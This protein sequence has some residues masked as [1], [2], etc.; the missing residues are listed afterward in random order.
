MYRKAIAVTLT[1]C[2]VCIALARPP[3]DPQEFIQSLNLSPKQLS[4]LQSA[5]TEL[6]ANSGEPRACFDPFCDDPD[7]GL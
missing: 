6:T 1:L 4:A 2:L 7:C 5:L 3:K